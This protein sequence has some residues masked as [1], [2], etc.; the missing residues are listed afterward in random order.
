MKSDIDI[1]QNDIGGILD[2]AKQIQVHQV[3]MIRLTGRKAQFLVRC[4]LDGKQLQVRLLG[5]PAFHQSADY[6]LLMFEHFI[7]GIC[8]GHLGLVEQTKQVLLCHGTFQL[9]FFQADAVASNLGIYFCLLL[10]HLVGR[11][12]QKRLRPSYPGMKKSAAFAKV[13]P[14]IVCGIPRVPPE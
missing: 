8:K 11:V 1:H 5:K 13:V 12:S 6:L 7:D 9:F 10:R 2:S 4:L 3:S 14:V